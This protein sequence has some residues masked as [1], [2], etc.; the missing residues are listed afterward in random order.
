MRYIVTVAV[1]LFNSGAAFAT[2]YEVD[3]SADKRCTVSKTKSNEYDCMIDQPDG[4]VKRT[5]VFQTPLP[6]KKTKEA[7]QSKK[8][9]S[10]TE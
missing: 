5:K 1:I 9:E 4:S 3:L 10:K 7:N 2:G 6:V 8:A